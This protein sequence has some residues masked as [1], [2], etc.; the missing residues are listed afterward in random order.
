MTQF[1]HLENYDI[2]SQINF[3]LKTFRKSHSDSQTTGLESP[4]NALYKG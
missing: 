1:S 2:E 4:G 3:P